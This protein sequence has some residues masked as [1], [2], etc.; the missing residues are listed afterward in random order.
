MAATPGATLAV[1]PG[2]DVEDGLDLGGPR[3]LRKMAEMD[4]VDPDRPGRGLDHPFQQTLLDGVLFQS[5]VLRSG[6]CGSRRSGG[7]TSTWCRAGGADLPG[8][9][10]RRGSWRRCPDR[11]RTPSDSREDGRSTRRP[12][13]SCRNVF[14]NRSTSCKAMTSS[15]STTAGVRSRSYRSST[16]Q[17]VLDVVSDEL[18]ASIPAV[19]FD[20]R[21]AVT[22][23]VPTRV[24]RPGDAVGSNKKT[25]AVVPGPLVCVV[26][27]RKMK[28]RA[29]AASAAAPIRRF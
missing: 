28:R 13:R 15:P 29:L 22:T 16:P 25:V 11:G 1:G 27:V 23:E 10:S 24:P 4:R 3:I 2:V 9:R 19:T 20:A 12:D 7:A 14:Q 17:P 21:G 26:I 6:N 18:H 5:A 8:G